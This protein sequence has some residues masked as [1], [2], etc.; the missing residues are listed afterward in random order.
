MA[1]TKPYPV[2]KVSSA[3]VF[4]CV[5]PNVMVCASAT[6]AKGGERVELSTEEPIRN[7]YSTVD[8]ALKSIKLLRFI[9]QED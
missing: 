4:Y 9:P 6:A 7:I 8:N 5:N 3:P 2:G 1:R